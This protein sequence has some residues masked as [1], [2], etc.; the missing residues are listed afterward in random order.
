MSYGWLIVD[1]GGIPGV[2]LLLFSVDGMEFDKATFANYLSVAILAGGE[3]SRM[4]Y[5]NKALVSFRKKPMIEHIL[6]RAASQARDTIIVANQDIDQFA[7]YPGIVVSDSVADKNCTAGPL[8]GMEAAL[9]VCQTPFMLVLPCDSPFLPHDL[10][11]RLGEAMFSHSTGVAVACDGLRMH[12][13][14]CLLKIT[15]LSSLRKFLASG[16]RK[17]LKWFEK[18]QYCTCDFSGQSSAFININ[19]MDE[20]DSL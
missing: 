9:Q 12:S 10:G 20:L 4:G 11:V 7:N 17:I 8:A 19:T 13:V 16:E 15:V 2:F 5:R 3:G 1:E 14:F 18:V 6:E